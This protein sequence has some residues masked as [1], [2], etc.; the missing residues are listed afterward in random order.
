MVGGN[1]YWL[2]YMNIFMYW[3]L[4][5]FVLVVVRVGEWGGTFALFETFFINIL[6]FV[7]YVSL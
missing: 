7:M 4:Y 3:W 1:L 6:H 5:I 2:F